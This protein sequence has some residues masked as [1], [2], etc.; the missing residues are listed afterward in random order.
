MK[1]VKKIFIGWLI[2]STF[3]IVPCASAE[4]LVVSNDCV[5][6]RGCGDIHVWAYSGG[7]CSEP[8]HATLS[9]GSSKSWDWGLCNIRSIIVTLQEG[10]LRPESHWYVKCILKEGGTEFPHTA[11][12][13]NVYEWNELNGSVFGTMELRCFK[14]TKP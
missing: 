13:W 1:R 3:A 12:G 11:T 7:L 5:E 14:E 2:L 4:K 9:P 6:G 10:Q 8:L